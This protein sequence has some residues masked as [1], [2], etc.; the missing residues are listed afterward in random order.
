VAPIG[1]LTP[2]GTRNIAL[3]LGERRIAGMEWVRLSLAALPNGQTGWVP[4]SAIGGYHFV[5]TRLIVDRTRETMTLFRRGRR[6]FTARVG[7]G[8]A[9]TPT[10]PGR[11]YI[12]DR[13]TGYADPF[14]GPIAFGTS[15]R[16]PVLT[17]WP[18]GGFVGIHGTNEPQRI[19]GHISH[20]CIR[21]RNPDILRLAGLLPVGTPIIVR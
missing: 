15:A 11:F 9:S 18:E 20:G 12:R 4:R 10:P 17:E 14:Y 7:V 3:V 16:S 1:T 6:V 5:R 2:E 8:R 13:L 21:L 19:P